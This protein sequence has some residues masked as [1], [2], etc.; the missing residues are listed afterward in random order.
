M[1]NI[2][3]AERFRELSNIEDSFSCKIDEYDGSAVDFLII[4]LLKVM[5]I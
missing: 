4:P 2:I 1:R 3:K 5:S